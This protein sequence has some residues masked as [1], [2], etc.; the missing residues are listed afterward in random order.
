MA[1][2]FYRNANAA[3]LIFS[4]TEYDSFTA[5]QR[6]VTELKRHVDA[7]VILTVV[8]NKIDLEDLREVGTR[9]LYI[10]IRRAVPTGYKLK[11]RSGPAFTYEAYG[12]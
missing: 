1:P 9:R 3:L 8:G 5:V 10:P 2:M 6:W 11:P 4:I 7:P 12:Y